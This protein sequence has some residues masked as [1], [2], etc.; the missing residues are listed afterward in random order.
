MED[1][2][3]S[4]GIQ[5]PRLNTAECVI[6]GHQPNIDATGV[7]SYIRAI[8]YCSLF[9]VLLIGPIL[10]FFSL[11]FFGNDP[12]A[13][14][15]DQFKCCALEQGHDGA[16]EQ[17]SSPTSMLCKYDY[18]CCCNERS[19]ECFK[20]EDPFMRP[21]KYICCLLVVTELL[22]IIVVSVVSCH[23]KE[24]FSHIVLIICEGAAVCLVQ[25]CPSLCRVCC[26]DSRKTSFCRRAVFITS[27]NIITY[28]LCWLIVG[29][30]VNPT[31]G[32]TVLAVACSVIVALFCTIYFICLASQ[33]IFFHRFCASIATFVGFCLVVSL[34]VVAGKS[35]YGKETTGEILK[36]ALWYVFGGLTGL[37]GKGYLGSPSDQSRNPNPN[38]NPNPNPNPN[39]NPNPDP[40]PNPNRNP[41]QDRTTQ[42]ESEIEL[43]VV[44]EE[45]NKLIPQGRS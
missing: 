30:M 40:N 19:F 44:K 2:A 14:E 34:T 6:Q 8:L 35:F 33:E 22:I 1:L 41:P 23:H 21:A 39:S 18:C 11:T 7:N 27:A 9:C 42:S 25:C 4:P 10:G 31:W 37:L 5:D 28:H 17:G 3:I 32:L 29:I 20:R 15:K 43:K 24:I 26:K 12:S 13:T 38:L 16:P 36:T 45:A